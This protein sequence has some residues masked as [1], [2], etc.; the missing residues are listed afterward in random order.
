[1]NNKHAARIGGDDY[2]HLYSWWL[3]LAMKF[4]D[5]RIAKVIIEDEQARSVDDVTVRHE[6]GTEL[7][8]RFYQ[9]KY[10]VNHRRAYSA[11]H[12]ITPELGMLLSSLNS[13]N[14]KTRSIGQLTVAL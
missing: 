9:I 8:D 11:E 5:T 7:P 2:Q 13:I 12:L 10:H 6:P 1:M 4:P 3:A 14:A